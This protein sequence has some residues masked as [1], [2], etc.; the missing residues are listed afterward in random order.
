MPLKAYSFK[1][2]NFTLPNVYSFLFI[3]KLNDLVTSVHPVLGRVSKITL[4]RGTVES[5]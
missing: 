2:N 1:E 3:R 4:I 5:N